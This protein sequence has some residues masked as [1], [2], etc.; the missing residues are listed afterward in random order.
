MELLLRGNFRGLSLIVIAPIAKMRE[1]VGLCPGFHEGVRYC[2]AQLSGEEAD[3]V[4]GQVWYD[5]PVQGF[6]AVATWCES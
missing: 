1:L 4:W 3:E 6:T 2:S 5:C